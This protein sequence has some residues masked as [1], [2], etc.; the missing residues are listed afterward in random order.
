MDINIHWMGFHQLS[1][2]VY[3]RRHCVLVINANVETNVF[4]SVMHFLD[5]IVLRRHPCYLDLPAYVISLQKRAF[6]YEIAEVWRR[7]RHLQRIMERESRLKWKL[8][9]CSIRGWTRRKRRIQRTILSRLREVFLD[10]GSTQSNMVWSRHSVFFIYGEDDS[11]AQLC[12]ASNNLFTAIVPSS[13]FYLAMI[14][15]YGG[16]V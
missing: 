6:H 5:L 8:L 12:G 4:R 3:L 11:R 13:W 2:D 14:T 10:I 9:T 16:L 15:V 7:I 1:L